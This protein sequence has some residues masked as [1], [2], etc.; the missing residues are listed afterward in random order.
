MKV[1]TLLIVDAVGFPLSFPYDAIH[2]AS[3]GF[4]GSDA[5]CIGFILF[6]SVLNFAKLYNSF[7]PNIRVTSI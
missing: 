6:A 7:A 3:P 4:D 1:S 2:T 5:I